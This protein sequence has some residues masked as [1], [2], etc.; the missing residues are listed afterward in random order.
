VA[1]T[2]PAKVATTTSAPAP[3]KVSAKSRAY[4][5]T[6]G[7][8]S[9]KGEKLFLIVGAVFPTEGAAQSALDAAL[10]RFGDMQPYF[11]VQSSNN[12]KGLSPDRWVVV[13]AYRAKPSSDN[14]L[15]ARRGFADA[16]VI[17]V[18]DLVTDPVPVYED[19]VG[20]D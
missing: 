18:T 16:H 13:E 17:A 2:L 5:K 6:L 3:V 19:L 4:A 8:W 11:I 20:G 15:F 1:T 10:P 7:G 9:H 14:M 12:F